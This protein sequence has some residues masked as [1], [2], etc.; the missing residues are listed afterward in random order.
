VAVWMC[1]C[2]SGSGSGSVAV[3]VA[4]AVAGW[5]Q[6]FLN[7]GKRSSIERDRAKQDG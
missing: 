5:W 2:G 7:G 1:G 6:W 4:V 3:A